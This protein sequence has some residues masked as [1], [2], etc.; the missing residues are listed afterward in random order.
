[1]SRTYNIHTAET[2]LGVCRRRGH[3]NCVDCCLKGLYRTCDGTSSSTVDKIRK[4]FD[5]LLKVDVQL[6]TQS[7][8]LKFS[9]CFELP[10]SQK[11]TGTAFRSSEKEPERRSGAFRLH[12][13][14][15]SGDPQWLSTTAS[16]HSMV[17]PA[18]KKFIF[19]FRV[20][21][22]VAQDFF[23]SHPMPPR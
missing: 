15:V 6:F 16:I 8:Q 9:V 2:A 5:C 7:T 17:F 20:A 11:G 19:S 1:M 22:G 12:W 10:F 13:S 23:G 18:T 14:S 4:P 3:R 21:R